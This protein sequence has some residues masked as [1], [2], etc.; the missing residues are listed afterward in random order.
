MLLKILKQKTSLIQYIKYMAKPKQ[1]KKEKKVV[2][3]KRTKLPELLDTSIEDVGKIESS[4]DLETIQLKRKKW[5]AKVSIR[6]TLP[7]SYRCYKVELSLDE[8]PYIRRIDDLEA[9]FN[10][11]LFATDNASIKQHDKN[12]KELRAKLEQLRSDCEDIEFTTTVDELKYKDGN[13]NLL[14]TLPDDVIE[15]FNRQ[16]A[17]LDIYKII[18]IPR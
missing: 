1:I 9:E 18:L 5:Q 14:I 11:T 17:R 7:K 6:T 13:T 3:K 8:A 15:P 16:K 12:L 4:L 2:F 10:G